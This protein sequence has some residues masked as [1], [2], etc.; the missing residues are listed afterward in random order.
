MNVRNEEAGVIICFNTQN[1]KMTT[2]RALV[3][4]ISAASALASSRMLVNQS[5]QYSIYSSVGTTVVGGKPYFAFA[6]GRASRAHPPP[7]PRAAAAAASRRRFR[8]FPPP[9]L[10]PRTFAASHLHCRSNS[11]ARALTLFSPTPRLRPHPS[12]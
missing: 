4:C 3:A 7:L 5:E 12:R 8:R 10:P 2:F 11:R 1:S 9:L 6:D